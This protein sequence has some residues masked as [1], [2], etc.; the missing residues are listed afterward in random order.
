MA[1]IELVMCESMNAGCSECCPKDWPLFADKS[2]IAP[3][4]RPY[5]AALRLK[6]DKSYQSAMPILLFFVSAVS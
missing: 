5:A 3:G 4:T 6:S 2:L 1:G